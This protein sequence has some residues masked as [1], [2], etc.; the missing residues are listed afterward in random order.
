MLYPMVTGFKSAALCI[1]YGPATCLFL[2]IQSSDLSHR[3]GALR[4]TRTALLLK[5]CLEQ[6]LS[7]GGEKELH[8]QSLCQQGGRW[9]PPTLQAASFL[10][11]YKVVFIEQENVQAQL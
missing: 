7:S 3:F 5:F 11:A 10:P 8:Y 4:A 9:G 1:T 6:R 2:F